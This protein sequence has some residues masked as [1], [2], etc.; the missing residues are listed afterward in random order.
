MKYIL[1]FSP[2]GDELFD[3]RTDLAEEHNL[4]RQQPDIA[5]KM[6]KDLCDFLRKYYNQ[7]PPPGKNVGDKAV[8]K[9]L[10]L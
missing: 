7:Q 6:D 5:A 3:L 8:R 9:R 10:G 2:Y 4:I 1:N